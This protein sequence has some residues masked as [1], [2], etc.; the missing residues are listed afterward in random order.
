MTAGSR[1]YSVLSRVGP[2]GLDYSDRTNLFAHHV[3]LDADELPRGGPAWLLRQ[4]GDNSSLT[5]SS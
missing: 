1:A 3:V 5:R 2:A 4:P